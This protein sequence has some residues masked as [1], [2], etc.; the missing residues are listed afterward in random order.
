MS[1]STPF[2]MV[3][4]AELELSPSLPASTER[5]APPPDVRYQLMHRT[6]SAII[7]AERFKTDDAALIVHSFSPERR[8]FED[9]AKFLSL[10]GLKAEPDKRFQTT[11]PSG[12]I[13]HL[14]WATG[15]AKFLLC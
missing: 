6:A 5:S 3:A 13:L 15:D 11:L 4:L 9:F 8:W 2:R 7:E 10:F 12:R 1:R 14:A